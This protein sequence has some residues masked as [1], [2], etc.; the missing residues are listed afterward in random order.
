[1]SKMSLLFIISLFISQIVFSKSL[2]LEGQNNCSKCNPMT[3]LCVRCDKDIYSPDKNGGCEN[4]KKCILGNNYCNECTEDDTLCKKCEEGFF[5]DSNGGCSYS[6]NCEISYKGECLECI[7]D[8]ILIGKE[9]N[10]YKEIKI[11]KSKKIDDFKNCLKIN[12]DFGFCEECEEDFYLNEGD[13]KCSNIKNCYESIYGKCKICKDGFY[14][15]KTS[16][17]CIEQKEHF[18]NCKESV[19]GEKCD[20]CIDD[21]YFDKNNNC[22]NTNNCNIGNIDKCEECIEGY[23]LSKNDNV[24]T[25]EKNCYYGDG[26][27]GICL[28]C[29][30]NYAIDFKDGKC[31]LNTEDNE[32]KYCLEIDGDCTKCLNGYYLGDDKKCS[33]VENCAESDKEGNCLVCSE[34]Y[35]LDLDNKC[36]N[37]EHC[38]HSD[39][40][41]CLQCEKEYFYDI[42]NKACI[43]SEKKFNNCRFGDGKICLLCNEEFYLNQKDNLCYNNTEK[44]KFYKCELTDYEGENCF[45]CINNYHIGFLD[46]KCTNI[47]G[48]EMINNEDKCLECSYNY[49][50]D[51]KNGICKINNYIYEE[52]EKFFY[53]CNKTNEMGDACEKCIEG[54]ILNDKGLCIDDIHCEEKENG[55]CQKCFA[56]EGEE[57]YYCLN[58][59]FGCVK[60]IFDKCLKCDNILDFD[61]CNL[62]WNDFHLN[63][64]DICI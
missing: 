51:V 16:N 37:I 8:Y 49:C 25:T 27:L 60:T 36:T 21:F 10:L 33:K 14:L 13:K 57:S 59:E 41:R 35:Y 53:R 19:D 50:L 40:G 58:T 52:E 48:C 12:T 31:K 18:L 9:N 30:E 32:Y 61:K 63:D 2:C 28:S 29:A 64:Y 39:F 46:K 23:Y 22:V 42:F 44:G 62:C 3:K 38:L 15:D 45:K 47:L 4:S 55:V 17:K 5:P 54:Y 43:L 56:G 6:N 1:M 7:E 34:N 26:E 11:C 20:K 24:C